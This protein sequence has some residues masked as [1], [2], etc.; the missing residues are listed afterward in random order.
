[1]YIGLT[2]SQLVVTV[3]IGLTQS[4]LVDCCVQWF[5]SVSVGCVV[6]H[7]DLVSVGCVVSNIGDSTQL[8]VLCTLV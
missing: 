5:D 8:V 7:C 2:R 3:Y 1:M 6:I 4:Q